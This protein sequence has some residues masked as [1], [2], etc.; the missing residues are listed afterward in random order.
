MLQ[1][2]PTLQKTV[3]LRGGR[4]HTKTIPRT[5][6]RVFEKTVSLNKI[7]TLSQNL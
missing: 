2:L 3:Q 4:N 7:R 6:T 5:C 1:K